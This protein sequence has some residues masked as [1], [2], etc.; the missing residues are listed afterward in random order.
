MTG[1]TPQTEYTP[2]IDGWQY[3]PKQ[4]LNKPSQYHEGVW[5][6]YHCQVNIDR[7]NS[8]TDYKE[9][10]TIGYECWLNGVELC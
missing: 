8:D 4:W 6:G 9:G 3:K 7:E 1:Y 10:V 5:D 2:M